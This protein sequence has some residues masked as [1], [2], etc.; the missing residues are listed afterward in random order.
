MNQDRRP[1]TAIPQ[2]LVS[3]RCAAWQLRSPENGEPTDSGVALKRAALARPT[4]PPP[5]PQQS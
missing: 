3:N 5:A 1:L 2:R 4:T